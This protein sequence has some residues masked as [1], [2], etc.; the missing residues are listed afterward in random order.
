MIVRMRRSMLTRLTCG[1]RSL[2]PKPA[3]P[4][5]IS[6]SEKTRPSTCITST[7]TQ[8]SMTPRLAPCERIPSRAQ[9]VVQTRPSILGRILFATP[10]MSRPSLTLRVSDLCM[11]ESAS[12]CIYIYVHVYVYV[13]IRFVNSTTVYTPVYH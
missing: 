3:P 1:V 13:Y 7:P 11:S 10:V 6:A 4:S 9:A 5:E 2:T 12:V 8:L